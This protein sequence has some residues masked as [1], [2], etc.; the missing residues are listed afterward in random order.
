MLALKGIG[1]VGKV[2]L[3]AVAVPSALLIC[4]AALAFTLVCAAP[5]RLLQTR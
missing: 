3:A 4:A 2:A 1:T 5:L